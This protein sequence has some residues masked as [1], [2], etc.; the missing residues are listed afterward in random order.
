[1]NLD[2]IRSRHERALATNIEKLNLGDMVNLREL[3]QNDIPALVAEI[4]RLRAVIVEADHRAL[5]FC[6]WTEDQLE[7]QP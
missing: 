5:R 2:D 6:T 3:L 1:M 7:E 4:G